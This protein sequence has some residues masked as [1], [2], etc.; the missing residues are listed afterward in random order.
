MT[1]FLVGSAFVALISI[2]AVAF[3][4]YHADKQLKEYKKRAS[5]K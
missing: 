4:W 3:L 5:Q 2:I 1:E